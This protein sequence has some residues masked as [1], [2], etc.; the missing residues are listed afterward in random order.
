MYRYPI[1]FYLAALTSPL[2]ASP[3]LNAANPLVDLSQFRVTTFATGIDFPTSMARLGDGSLLVGSTLPTQSF[4]GDS[5][6]LNFYTGSGRLLRFTDTDANG[7]ADGPAVVVA[8]GLAGAITSV[9]T[10]GGIVAVAT[11]GNAS[12]PN[13]PEGAIMFFRQGASP[14]DSYVSLGEVRF[15]YSTGALP[16]FALAVR[17]TPGQPGKFD[18]AFALP[19]SDHFGSDA[20][21]VTATGLLSASLTPGSA[22]RTTVDPASGSF[23]LSSLTQVASGRS[24]LGRNNL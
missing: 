19:G 24:H 9:Q 22:W 14:N 5:G 13:S 4:S 17:E 6:Y 11:V 1:F 2:A 15:T 21:T 10:F 18:L 20:G 23:G 3:V 16:T 8:S 7:V 12:N